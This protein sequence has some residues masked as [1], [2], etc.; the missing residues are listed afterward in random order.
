M[1]LNRWITL[2][3]SHWEEHAPARFRQLS[4]S[5]R[6]EEALQ[7]AAELTYRETS[8][9]E[10]AGYSPDE[11]WQMV[12]ENYLLLPPESDADD[13]P[14]YSEGAKLFKETVALNNKI[15]RYMQT[16]DDE[17]LA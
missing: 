6:L 3:R 1:N 10:E 16:G 2:A 7:E 15:L 11:A 13:K 12:R 14:E 8:E 4:E 5:G 9:L 17:D